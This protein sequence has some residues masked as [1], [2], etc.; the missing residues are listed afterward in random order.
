LKNQSWDCNDYDFP[1]KFLTVR[2]S[3]CEKSFF[4]KSAKFGPEN[5]ILRKCGRKLVLN[6]HNTKGIWASGCVPDDWT[7][8]IILPFYKGKGSRQECKN[9]RGI[10]LLSCPGKVSTHLIL[11]RVKNNLL[12]VRRPEQSGF[13]PKR[14]TVDL[15]T[16][17]VSC[18]RLNGAL[19]DWFHF[20]SGIRQ[21]CTVAPSLFLLPVDWILHRVIHRGFLGAT[22]GTE[23][24]IDLDY[25]D[26]AALLAEMLE[27]LLLAL[28]VLNDE[29]RPLGLE[30]NW[31]KTKIQ[32]TIDSATTPSSVYISGN[33]VE[34]VESFVYLGSEIHSSGSSEPEVL[35][36]IGLAKSCFNLLNRGIWRSSISVLT[37]VQLYRT[38]I[39]PVLLYGSE[40]WALTRAL[41][42]KVD[43]FDNICLR[44]ILRMVY[45]D[46]VANATVR[47]RAGSPLQLSQLIQRSRLRLFGHVAR[48]DE[49]L[50][51]SRALKTSVRGLP[52]EWK[53]PSERPRHTWLRTLGADLQPHNHGLNSAWRCAQDREH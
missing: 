53:R 6:T 31:Q 8:G 51:I 21:G 4:S 36:R 45:V 24:F 10:T 30:V 18:V 17:T 46:H 25:A 38:Y 28:D 11:D 7:K 2:K 37:K 16:N 33:P 52:V 19:S 14:S 44:R 9:Y 3:S 23:I 1:T 48:M 42:D 20:G 34:V 22:L 35:R 43:A 39:Q 27:V 12:S 40:T 13:T 50:D 29:A 15:Y 47:L 5:R 49:S 26:D 41:L 32:S